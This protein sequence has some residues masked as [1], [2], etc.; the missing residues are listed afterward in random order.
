MSKRN[1]SKPLSLEPVAAGSKPSTPQSQPDPTT[2][3]PPNPITPDVAT[4]KFKLRVV[5][6][7]GP[8]DLTVESTD[9]EAAKRRVI[10]DFAANLI[11][12]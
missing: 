1:R 5:G 3:S 7:F 4:R 10:D 9:I 11:E 6:T 2:S 8:V 12:G